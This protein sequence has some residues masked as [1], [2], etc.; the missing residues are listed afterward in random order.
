M[1]R[2]NIMGDAMAPTLN[3]G[4]SAIATRRFDRL[5]RGDIVALRYPR[6]ELKSFVKRIVGLPG[7]RIEMADGRVSIDGR[8]LDE[9]YV[10]DAN[11]SRDTWG[12]RTVPDG[13]YFV[14]GD[15]R[16]NSSDS[17]SWGTVTHGAIWAKIVQ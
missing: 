2:V 11:R 1:L 14:M 12:P 10:L 8:P 16:R 6:D 3:D 4:D 7:E 9:P 15:N 5:D 17:R 13:E